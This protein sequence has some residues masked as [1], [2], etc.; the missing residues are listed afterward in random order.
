MVY[1]IYDIPV[2]KVMRME[3]LIF[4]NITILPVLAIFMGAAYFTSYVTPLAHS[5]YLLVMNGLIGFK[6]ACGFFIL[7]YRY[8]A[9]E[10]L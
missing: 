8:I 6:V 2:K 3:E 4:I 5:I 7:F 1:N 9:I 10:R